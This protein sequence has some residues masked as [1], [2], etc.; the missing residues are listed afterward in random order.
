[1]TKTT[2]EGRIKDVRAGKAEMV[3]GV[4]EQYKVDYAVLRSFIEQL[5]KELGTDAEPRFDVG[6]LFC[7]K[8]P[9]SFTPGSTP[10]NAVIAP[11]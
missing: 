1:M 9:D 5:C 4:G 11:L 7:E 2:L 6:T 8:V 10:A 3:L